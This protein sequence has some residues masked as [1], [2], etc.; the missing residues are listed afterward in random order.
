MYRKTI[1]LPSL[2]LSALLTGCVGTGPN[3]QNG[4]VGGAALGALAGAIIGNNSG[5]HNGAGGALI[6]A[7]AGGLAGGTIGNARDNQDG[8]AY[9][10]QPQQQVAYQTT[11]VVQPEPVA[12]PAAPAPLTDIVTPSPAANALWVPGYWDFN[13]TSYTWTAGHW[14]I[15]P[16]NA[17]TY[18]AA[19][20]ETRAGANVFVRGY[21]R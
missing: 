4:A 6:G 19:H 13:G 17:A 21:W 20:W 2:A 12:P 11:T 9:G 8:T 1:L 15:P 5:G 16:P 18:I 14:E 7:L 10:A 3:T